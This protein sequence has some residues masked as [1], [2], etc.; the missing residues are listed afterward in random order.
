MWNGWF[1]RKI[2]KFAY[3]N[4]SEYILQSR[5]GNQESEIE[6]AIFDLSCL[7]N[8]LWISVAVH[9]S[10]AFISIQIQFSTPII[11]SQ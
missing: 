4:R 2:G 11:R 10:E 5:I 8:E 3:S 9:E 6:I 7:L 1:L